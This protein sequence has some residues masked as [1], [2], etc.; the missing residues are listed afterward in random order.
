MAVFAAHS[1]YQFEQNL[2]SLR[3]VEMG[4]LQQFRE[5][6]STIRGN[7]S[8]LVVGVDIAK[9]KHYAFFGIANGITLKKKLIFG[10]CIQDFN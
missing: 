3:E 7:Q 6:R 4:R 2:M 10:N 9:E 8:I 1:C 5:L